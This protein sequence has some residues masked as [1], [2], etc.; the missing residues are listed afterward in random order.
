MAK[1]VRKKKSRTSGSG[2][3]RASVGTT[4]D[5]TAIAPGVGTLPPLVG[6]ASPTELEAARGSSDDEDESDGGE[7]RL[8]DDTQIG[9]VL[10][11]L[12]AEQATHMARLRTRR[13]LLEL[14]RAAGVDPSIG[15]VL[16]R[17]DDKSQ[18]ILKTLIGDPLEVLGQ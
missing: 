8:F 13:M 1:R 3:S 15:T 10:R 6:V 7:E 12:W 14:A 11:E 5:L 2:D 17:P 4:A 16:P 9:N 18:Q